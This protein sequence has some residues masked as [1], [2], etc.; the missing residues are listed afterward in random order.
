MSRCLRRL[1]DFYNLHDHQ[2]HTRFT[3]GTYHTVSR[4]F[5]TVPDIASF[6]RCVSAFAVQQPLRRQRR[7]L[8]LRLYLSFS[9]SSTSFS[10][11]LFFLSFSLLFISLALSLLSLALSLSRAHSWSPFDGRD[12]GHGLSQDAAPLDMCRITDGV[13]ASME[14]IHVTDPCH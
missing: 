6:C 1:M 12:G 13:R 9:S 14:L 5:V 3:A 11:P 8:L 4:P 2:G 10:S 7:L